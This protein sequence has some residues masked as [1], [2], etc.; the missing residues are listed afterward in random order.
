MRRLQL[1]IVALF[2]AP[3]C[4]AFFTEAPR[5][6]PRRLH[7]L[8]ALRRRAPVREGV[9]VDD[10]VDQ[11]TNA[12]QTLKDRFQP[13]LD[14]NNDGKVDA[15]DATLALALATAT[16]MLTV[17]PTA[18]AA[19]GGGGGGGGGGGLIVARPVA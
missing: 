17:N 13:S 8:A 6:P 16:A 18:A 10:L 9:R 2:A 15:K 7:S 14:L 5:R 1:F 11:T 19:K 4:G 3:L 12:L